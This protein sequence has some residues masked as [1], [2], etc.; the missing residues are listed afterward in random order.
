MA[1]QTPIMTTCEYNSSLET[2]ANPSGLMI[3]AAMEAKEAAEKKKKEE[4]SRKEKSRKERKRRR[5]TEDEV[6]AAATGSQDAPASV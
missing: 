5:S 2:K 1:V 4:K 3:R 6:T